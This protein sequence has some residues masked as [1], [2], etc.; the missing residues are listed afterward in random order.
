MIGVH[1]CAGTTVTFTGQ[2]FHTITAETAAD[3]CTSITV[4]GP[5][6]LVC[7]TKAAASQAAVDLVRAMAVRSEHTLPSS[8]RGFASRNPPFNCPP[9]LMLTVVLCVGSAALLLFRC[10]SAV[11]AAATRRTS[12]TT[13]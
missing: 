13:T 2:N 3:T 9:R 5:T 8:L 1:C 10:T 4:Q 7:T 6:S 11:S 12:I